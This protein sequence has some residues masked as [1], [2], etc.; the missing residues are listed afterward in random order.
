MPQVP[1]KELW[2]DHVL[3]DMQHKPSLL[4][5]G[6]VT[7]NQNPLFKESDNVKRMLFLKNIE[8]F[9]GDDEHITDTPGMKLTPV[10]GDG[11]TEF[12][13]II[14]RGKA[15]KD[16]WLNR[17]RTGLDLHKTYAPQFGAYQRIQLQKRLNVVLKA[18]F[19]PT[20]GPLRTSHRG[21][22]STEKLVVNHINNQK[23]LHS[24]NNEEAGMQLKMLMVHPLVKSDMANRSTVT[25]VPAPEGMEWFANGTKF[26]T[27]IG[28]AVVVENARM[29]ATVG[30][31]A[32][33]KPVYPSYLFGPNVL[34]VEWQK[35]LEIDEDVIYENGKLY[36]LQ[37]LYSVCVGIKGLTFD[38]NIT[39][40]SDAQLLDPDNWTRSARPNAE[41]PVR[42]ILTHI[43]AM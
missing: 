39:N 36:Y 34:Y 41:I 11:Y 25:Y 33:G 10:E 28:D 40:P 27:K 42:Q 24:V 8:E 32:G 38:K 7:F 23:A 19:D 20:A 26:L 4:N 3:I 13:P 14:Q 6:V 15:F 22:Y 2:E 35:S 43:D 5:S 37:W 31:N 9:A 16:K 21:D 12:A 18:V 17:L 29:C 30:N 1:H